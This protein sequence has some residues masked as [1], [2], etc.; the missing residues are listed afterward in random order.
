MSLRDRLDDDLKSA[1]RARDSLRLSV[2]RGVKAAVLQ[3]ETR[4][5]RK[6]LDDAGIVQVIAKEVKERQDSIAEFERASRPE[7]VEKL[8]QEMQVLQEYLP[9]PL[10]ESEL[11]ELI[12]EAIHATGAGGPRD[13]G[14]VMGWLSPKTRG[15]ADGAIVSEHV[16]TKLQQLSG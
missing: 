11:M 12:D 2:I 9:Q 16:R 4:G 14:R 13:L 7:L 1:M 15:R 6:T 8:V 10:T 3:A 5:E